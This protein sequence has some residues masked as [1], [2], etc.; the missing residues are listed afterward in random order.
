MATCDGEVT[1]VAT[2][3]GNAVE[4]RR[5]CQSEAGHPAPCR[6]QLSLLSI[7]GHEVRVDVTWHGPDAPEVPQQPP[8]PGEWKGP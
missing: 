1:I 6:A 2:A 4:K 3:L 7:L 8:R 5:S